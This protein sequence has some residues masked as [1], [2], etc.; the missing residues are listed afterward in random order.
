VLLRENYR[1]YGKTSKRTV[2]NLT[3]WPDKLVEDL[4]TLLKGGT[5]MQPPAT[6]QLT[7]L[8]ALR[9][10]HV[11][12]VPGAARICRACCSG[13]DTE[14]AMNTKTSMIGSCCRAE[15]QSLGQGFPNSDVSG[16]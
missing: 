5:A 4:R 9:H 16:V 14:C 11:A 6:T 7:V 8:H 13:V 12:A 3:H 1:A 10:S 2:V 15:G